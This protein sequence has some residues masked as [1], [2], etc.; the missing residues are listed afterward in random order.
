MDGVESKGQLGPIP[1]DPDLARLK[2]TLVR[3]AF[4]NGPK[5]VALLRDI[6]GKVSQG[7][8]DECCLL[9]GILSFHSII[10]F[11]ETTGVTLGITSLE[12][13]FRRLARNPSIL[14]DLDEI[15]SGSL[16]TTRSAGSYRN[17]PL[18]VLLNSM[19]STASKR[20]RLAWVRRHL[21]RRDKLGLGHFTSRKK[22][23][24]AAHHLSEDGKGVLA[25]HHVC[26]L[27]DQQGTAA[28]GV[29]VEHD[30]SIQR[31]GRTLFTI[32]IAAIRS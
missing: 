11:G 17:C 8:I 2:K 7:A 13:V 30:R 6:L 22:D 25:E 1:I 31:P 27:P 4:I 15:L 29:T 21:K 20:S 32:K 12:D 24:Y 5:E 9:Q 26:R 10:G 16:E 28:L 23:L 18:T 14:A 19:H 3:A